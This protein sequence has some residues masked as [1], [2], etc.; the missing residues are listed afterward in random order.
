MYT[1]PQKKLVYVYKRINGVETHT[2]TEGWWP[3]DILK[4]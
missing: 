4:K 2:R 3:S 1:P